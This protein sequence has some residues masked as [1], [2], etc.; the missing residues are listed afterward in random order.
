M[1][2]RAW[3]FHDY[4]GSEV[5]RLETVE[6]AEPG[7][8]EVL[9]RIKA[10]GL[11]RSDLLWTGAGFFKPELPAQ[12]G[13]EICG[14]IERCGP[15]VEGFA[16]GDRVNNLPVFT[17]GAE[18]AYANFADYAVIPVAELIHTPDDLSDAEGAAFLFTNLT[19][20]CALTETVQLRAGQTLLITA[21]TSAN[22]LS[23]IHHGRQLGARVIATT[24][25]ADKR[26]LLLEAGADAVVATD[27]ETLS[28]RVAEITGGQG[29][30]VIY[31]CVGGALTN[32]LVRSLRPGGEW[33]MYGYLDPSP[34]T[35]EWPLWFAHQPVLHVYSLTQYTGMREL[36]LPGRPIELRRAIDAV[37][38]LCG[39]GAIPVP[40]ARTFKGI[41]QVQEAFR[42]MEANVGG[43]K[44]V[45]EF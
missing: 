17:R 22:G 6:L 13:C 2:N 41:E 8:G 34:F 38:A 16:P 43:G 10:A 28:E 18:Y 25:S 45:V 4:G 26:N 35:S 15:D 33:V 19:Q 23:A 29:A 39:S 9:V 20:I 42:L 11:N 3:R 36:N 30:D 27:S 5:M 31:D 32:E 44:I 21:A 1:E 12:L 40:I 14:V 37:K 24:R 7:P